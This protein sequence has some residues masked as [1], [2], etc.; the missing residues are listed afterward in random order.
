LSVVSCP[1]PTTDNRSPTTRGEAALDRSKLTII[2]ETISHYRIVKKLGSGGMGEVYLAE[3]MKLHR[4]VAL[5][6]LLG[7]FVRDRHRLERFLREAHAASVIAHPNVAVIHEIG[8]ADDQTPFI[9]MEYVEG[10]TLA[11]KIGGHPLPLPDLMDIGVE[12]AEALDEAHA[13]GVV[14][15]D[16][17]PANII[18]TPRG[19]AKV[20]DFGLAKLRQLSSDTDSDTSTRLK[21]D[22]G[23]VLGTVHYMSP[24]QA[25]GHDVDHRSDLFSLGVV[26]YEMATGRQ[27]FG[28]RTS[29]ETIERIVHSQPEAI[30]RFNYEVPQELERIIRKCLEK[31]PDW[32][33]QSG[34][35]LLIDLRNLRRDSTSAERAPVV[36]RR[37][38]WIP[39]SI[40]AAVVLI[41]LAAVLAMRRTS[42]VRAPID[43]LAVLPFV[44]SSRDPQSEFLA[45][46]MTEAIINKLTEL[47]QLKV[48]S[49][50]TMFR[51]KGKNADPQQV[52]RELKVS[53]VLAGRVRQVGDRLDIQTELVNVSDGSQL[54]GERYDRRVADVFALQDDIAREIS[55]K[56]RL[57]LTGEEQKRLGKRYTD[58]PE[59][60]ALYVQGRF[61][62]NKRT[63]ASIE[64]ALELFNQAL[65]R[66]P[67]YALAH[68]GVA[69]CYAI[70]PQYA[71]SPNL[72]SQNR[73]KAAVARAL[74]IDPQ[75]AEAHATLGLIHRHLWEWQDA[76]SEFKRAIEL[77]PNYATAHHWYAITVRTQ[78]RYA[79][80]LAETKKAQALDPL[81]LIINT[82]LGTDLD[83]NGRRAEAIEQFRRTIDLDPTFAFAHMRLGR[84]YL[85]GGDRQNGLQELEKAAELGGRTA[86]PVSELGYAYAQVGR[87][88]DALKIISELRQK[89]QDKTAA[90]FRIGYVYAALGD[91]TEAYRWFDQALREHDFFLCEIHFRSHDFDSWRSDPHFQQLLRGMNLA[92]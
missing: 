14:H 18:I 61:Y 32:R 64:K 7:E 91:R 28:G 88:G 15:R 58:K 50:S 6:V 78:R 20:L 86:E 23:V 83:A 47:P 75:L 76:E 44:N 70:L 27:A 84:L 73:A 57:K 37:R 25:L 72:E 4:P 42:N 13:R 79:E 17:K 52:G 8:E 81:S 59:A 2:Q 45:D 49:R 85:E 92:K 39:L 74:E 46:G 77:K 60:Y 41:A 31:N 82:N 16:L 10:Q 30:A 56:L 67:N 29:T 87:R 5:K 21:S 43:S 26:L 33:Y 80:A 35:D 48:M 63:R 55:E 40:V 62:W 54:W 36:V 19:H 9:A 51:Y 3:D 12:I 53:A 24:E 34:R 90:P 22:P 11:A 66:D 89:L 1:R 38:P 71:G 69:D 65:E 68:L